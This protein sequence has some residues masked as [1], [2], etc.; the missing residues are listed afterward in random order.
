MPSA[1]T[2]S[3]VLSLLVLA[4]ILSVA[5]W[6]QKAPSGDDNANDGDCVLDQSDCSF[7][8]GKHSAV[9]SLSPRPI[10]IEEQIHFTFDIP[11]EYRLEEAHIEGVNMYMGRTIVFIDRQQL[12]L[13]GISFLG[14]CSEP[15]MQWK[16]SMV[17]SRDG[18]S[19]YRELYFNTTLGNTIL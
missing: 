9:V 17:F 18:N 12:P 13:T 6:L 1:K 8:L 7:K 2:L 14:S 10:P 19:F 16:L 15:S 3:L 4:V 11:D 5:V